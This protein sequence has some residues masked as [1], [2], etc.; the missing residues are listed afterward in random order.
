ME[1]VELFA[2]GAH[3]K[4]VKPLQQVILADAAVIVRVRAA[5]LLAHE[6]EKEAHGALL[7]L[8]NNRRKLLDYLKDKDNER[9]R[10][11]I[12]RLGLRR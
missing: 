10:E 6:P 7:K 5:E 9:Y 3:Q 1:A 4:L 11:V 8:V 2:T 12:T